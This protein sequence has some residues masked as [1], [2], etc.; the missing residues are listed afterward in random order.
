MALQ[1]E[2]GDG[3]LLAQTPSQQG[4]TGQGTFLQSQQSSCLSTR[5]SLQHTYPSQQWSGEAVEEGGELKGRDIPNIFGPHGQG[6]SP[7]GTSL[8]T[9]L[10]VPQLFFNS[11]LDL[12]PQPDSVPSATVRM[13]PRGGTF[14]PCPRTRPQQSLLGFLRVHGFWF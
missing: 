12:F 1:G 5:I 6:W 9:S 13:E 10:L 11:V 4:L 3:P 2:M 8:S 14:C 7:W